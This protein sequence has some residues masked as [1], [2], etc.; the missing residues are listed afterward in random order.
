MQL[1]WQTFLLEKNDCLRE[2][3]FQSR[4]FAVVNEELEKGFFTKFK[5]RIRLSLDESARVAN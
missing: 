3:V 4:C 5:V 2:F 1:L